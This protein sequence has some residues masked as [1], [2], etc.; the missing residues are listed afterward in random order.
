[1][2]TVLLEDYRRLWFLAVVHD[3]LLV[4]EAFAGL[5]SSWGVQEG[6]GE[7][8]IRLGVVVDRSSNGI[9]RVGRRRSVRAF[10]D[11]LVAREYLFRLV[12]TASDLLEVVPERSRISKVPI[13]IAVPMISSKLARF[14]G[15]TSSSGE[16]TH[17]IVFTSATASLITSRSNSRQRRCGRRRRRRRRR[18][19]RPAPV[20]MTTVGSR[21]KVR[22]GLDKHS[23]AGDLDC[24][25]HYCG[26]P[27]RFRPRKL[28]INSLRRKF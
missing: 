25:H 5:T 22:V 17:L 20:V 4:Q 9:H 23:V 19:G 13:V 26:L 18:C 16:S 6:D 24:S 2:V 12:P 8:I 3:K 21:R 7:L 14:T 10:T 27:S 1:M 11:L 28:L 15:T